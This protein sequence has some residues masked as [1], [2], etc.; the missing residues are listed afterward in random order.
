MMCQTKYKE[1]IKYVSECNFMGPDKVW[2][3]GMPGEAYAFTGDTT[4][5]RKMISD[6]NNLSE[7][8]YIS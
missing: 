6:L 5:A 2:Y 8:R 4:R 3:F 7:K 1:F